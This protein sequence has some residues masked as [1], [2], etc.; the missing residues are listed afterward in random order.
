MYPIYSIALALVTLVAALRYLPFSWNRQRLTKAQS[1]Q[2]I[3]I[4]RPNALQPTCEDI[5][6]A[7][8]DPSPLVAR[9]IALG[10]ATVL[11]RYRASQRTATAQLIIWEGRRKGLHDSFYDLGARKTD[12]LGSELVRDFVQLGRE[13]LDAL[14]LTGT[15]CR[16]A[17]RRASPRALSPVEPEVAQRHLPTTMAL[18]STQVSVT[19]G[20][21]PLAVVTQAQP[22]PSAQT[23]KPAKTVAYPSITRGQLLEAGLMNKYDT[24]T[25]ASKR[26]YGVLVR[27]D[28]TGLLTQLWGSALRDQLADKRIAI[29]DRVEIV[30]LGRQVVEP[31]KAPMNLYSVA[32]I[33]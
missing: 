15:T 10:V 26:V 3:L 28:E 30:K 12:A 13:K 27:D 8:L 20:P 1:T 22:E 17:K 2:P 31:D 25:S 5:H 7:V 4:V 11:V 9:E 18:R 6:R 33:A 23:S 32:K 24:S 29:H 21:D 14:P 19:P 16:A